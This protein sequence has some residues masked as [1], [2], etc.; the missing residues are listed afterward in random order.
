MAKV[1]VEDGL[2]PLVKDGDGMTARDWAT[3]KAFPNMVRE[4][5]REGGSTP[6]PLSTPHHHH[7]FIQDPVIRS[8]DQILN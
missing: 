5:G 7:R 4:G 1:L 8:C 3:K 2:D 6:Q